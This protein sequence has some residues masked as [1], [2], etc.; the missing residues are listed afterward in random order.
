VD[1]IPEFTGYATNGYANITDANLFGVED[2]CTDSSACNTMT[3]Y[4]DVTY[5]DD[6]SCTFATT[7]Y[8][9][10]GV[11]L[12]DV[13][14][15][16]VCDE[17]EVAG[18]QDASA[19]NYNVLATDSDGSCDYPDM[20]YNCAGQCISDV[21][22]DGVCDELE[23]EGCQDDAYDNYDASAT[24]AGTCSGLLGCTD[25]GYA[26][27]YV[28]FPSYDDLLYDNSAGHE[29]DDNSC[30]TKIVTGCTNPA[31]SNFN[32][33]ANVNITVEY[34]HHSCIIY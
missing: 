12:N 2:G 19:C 10:D 4:A 9:C 6:G 15:D 29:V 14:G 11:C 21:D 7:G 17:F 23:V 32:P 22:A 28:S 18:C 5:F 30:T 33:D 24:D 26:E 3:M 20:Y 27:Y 25:S 1:E 8:D 34:H 31:A 16:T 13:D